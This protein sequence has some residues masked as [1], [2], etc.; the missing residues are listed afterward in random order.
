MSQDKNNNT[1]QIILLTGISG[2]G[3]T[4]L[5]KALQK[6]L[7]GKGRKPVEFIDGD[8]V[9]HFFE[10]ES[11]YKLE[12]RNLVTKHIAYGAYLLAQNGI[13]VIV[14]NIAGKHSIRNFL[15]RKWKRYIQVFLDADIK[16]CVNNDQ[17][18]IYK[19][20]FKLKN[21]NIYGLDIPYERPRNP[22]V[23]VY[24]YKESVEESLKKILTYLEIHHKNGKKFSIYR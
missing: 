7:A 18:N 6:F 23:I 10:I 19:R 2:S 12:E 15:K 11:T 4:T 21:P 14:A 1:G 24:P 16:D 13:D 9:R 20:A 3:K 8:K 5:G 17:K 22:D